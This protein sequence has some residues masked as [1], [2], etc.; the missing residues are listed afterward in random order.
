MVFNLLY[1]LYNEKK[2]F[3]AASLLIDFDFTDNGNGTGIIT[4]W[5]GTFNGVAS[6]E[7]IIPDDPSIIL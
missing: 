3:D 4:D 6:T 7:L 5:K 2:P 1:Y